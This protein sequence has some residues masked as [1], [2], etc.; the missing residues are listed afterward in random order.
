MEQTPVI[1]GGVVTRLSRGG[2]NKDPS[3][4]PTIRRGEEKG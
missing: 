3:A 2:G 4:S 1:Q